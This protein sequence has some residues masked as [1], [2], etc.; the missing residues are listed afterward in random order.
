M[1]STM[2]DTPCLVSRLLEHGRT[3][4]GSARGDHLDGRRAAADDATPR[5]ARARPSWPTRCATTSGSP[6]TSG[7]RTLMWNNAEHLVAYLA[8]PSM[9]AVLHTLNLRLF[10]EQLDLHRQPRRGPRHPRRLDA[11]PAAGRGAA[12]PDDAA[13]H[14]GG[15][16]RRRRTAARVA[17]SRRHGSPLGGPARRQAGPRTT[18][19]S[20][21]RTTPPRCA[22]PPARPGNPKGVAYSH[23][24]IYLHSMQVCSAEAFG[25]GPA[26]QGA[27]RGADVPRDG[28]GPAVRRLP[29][30]RV[31]ADAGPVPAGRP[32]RRDDR[33]GA[34]RRWPARC[35][36]SG[37]TC[38]PT[39]TPTRPTSRRMTRGHRRRL[40]LPAGAHARL[41]RAAR[42][43]DHPRLG[44]DRDVA[45]GLG[46]PRAGRRST[47]P[48][49]WAYRYTQGRVP[50][51]VRGPHRRPGRRRSCPTTA[52][53]SASSRSAARGSPRRTSATPS[54]TRRS[55]R[56]GW[57]RTGDVGVLSPD[58]YLTL[59][60]R[61]KDVI[62]SG[63]EWISSV[64]LENAL[65]GHPAV[66]E[67][68][69]VGVPDE[70]W[71]ERPL[72][73]VVL[74]EG[75]HGDGRRAARVPRRDRW[76]AGSC[77]SGGPSSRRC[78]RRRW[79]SSTRS[80]S[81][82]PST[83]KAPSP[84]PRPRL[85]PAAPSQPSADHGLS[86]SARAPIM[87]LTS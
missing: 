34:A 79:A 32:A 39:S 12:A 73:T 27:R 54:R 71:G 46:V 26:T 41:L 66:L 83:P 47:G 28:V 16:R 8:V 17:A 58:G 84:S 60:D 59:T 20:W 33:R 63:G 9:G 38:S 74:R 7:S 23:R 67:A 29:V 51:S 35:R 55:S 70:R 14:R 72:A 24:S 1:R 6:A 61:A 36:R 25:L 3:V 44:H 37:P 4:H 65:M 10:P 87:T 30:R 48:E 43:R 80:G 64:E 69:V 50:A 52:R 78:R 40:G 19:R 11:D 21:T 53:P 85:T 57:L 68:C 56:D 31:A 86:T 15:R 5:S 18:G 2:M 22:T 62:K 45:A 42:H 13:P 75:A 81:A 76:P 49:A 77:P 82:R